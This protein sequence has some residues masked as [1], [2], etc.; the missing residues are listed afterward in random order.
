MDAPE[1]MFVELYVE[2]EEK[3]DEIKCPNAIQP[4]SGVFT[5]YSQ[6]L[7][8]DF[9]IED[10]QFQP[11]S[12]EFYSNSNM[13]STMFYGASSSSMVP[14]ITQQDAIVSPLMVVQRIIDPKYGEI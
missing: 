12:N 11:N 13:H 1:I 4:D 7:A 10:V 14:Y 8:C 2:I 3:D 5:Q 6:L 9:S